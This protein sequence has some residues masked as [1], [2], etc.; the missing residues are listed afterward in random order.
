MRK[1][2]D[3][4][5]GRRRLGAELLG[6][7]RLRATLG[8]GGGGRCFPRHRISS[9]PAVELRGDAGAARCL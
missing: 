5:R 7:G 4:G 6:E 1:G 2:N 9:A 3:R 8:G